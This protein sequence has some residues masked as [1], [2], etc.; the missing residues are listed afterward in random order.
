MSFVS[1]TISDL[2]LHMRT[3]IP[4]RTG[5]VDA[6]GAASPVRSRLGNE[7]GQRSRVIASTCARQLAPLNYGTA[8]LR[9]RGEVGEVPCFSTVYARAYP[10]AYGPNVSKFT[11]F[12]TRGRLDD[13]PRM[14][15]AATS[16]PCRAMTHSPR[17]GAAD[18]RYDRDRRRRLG[19]VVPHHARAHRHIPTR[20]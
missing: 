15:P 4:T 14:R 1:P 6:P 12:T 16:A 2:P 20:P 7:V 5:S 17:R 19:I 13:P 18:P 10:R 11:N 9:P 8:R 3:M